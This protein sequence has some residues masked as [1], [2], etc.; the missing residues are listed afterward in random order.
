[1]AIEKGNVKIVQLL[2]ERENININEKS[3]SFK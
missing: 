1:M 2:L 3:I